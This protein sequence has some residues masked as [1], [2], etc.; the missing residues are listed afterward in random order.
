M[1]DERLSTKMCYDALKASLPE[2]FHNINRPIMSYEQAAEDQSG[3]TLMHGTERKHRERKAVAS[4]SLPESFRQFRTLE[5]QTHPSKNSPTN[6]KQGCI[7]FY[8]E[9]SEYASLS[10]CK[11]MTTV[12]TTGRYRW[13]AIQRLSQAT[14]KS[15][16]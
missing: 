11:L 4:G 14:Q 12:A 6:K 1:S 15:P 10:V 13:S 2:E 7:S 5:R 9:S 3:S 16:S 8:R